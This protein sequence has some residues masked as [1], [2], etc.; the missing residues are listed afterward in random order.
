MKGALDALRAQRE[1][2]FAGVTSYENPEDRLT[3]AKV[4]LSAAEPAKARFNPAKA[5]SEMLAGKERQAGLPAL[6][7]ELEVGFEAGERGAE[8]L[9]RARRFVAMQGGK[10]RAARMSEEERIESARK[11]GSAPKKRRGS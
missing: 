9:L 2:K 3:R 4:A 5:R 11:A 7:A 8:L 1:A 10:A 6:V